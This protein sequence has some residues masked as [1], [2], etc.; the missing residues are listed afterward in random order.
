MAAR[1]RL[2]GCEALR[3]ETERLTAESG[4]GADI[5]AEWLE[6][7]LHQNPESLGR[8]LRTRLSALSGAGYETVLLLFGLCGRATDGLE[9]PPGAKL[10]IPRVHDC[11]SIFLGSARRYLE[12]VDAE[13]GSYWL[14]RT[15]LRRPDRPVP[16]LGGFGS[17]WRDLFPDAGEVP[18][19][20]EEARP[21]LIER[22]GEDNA[23]YLIETLVESWRRNYRRAVH[24]D[25]SD[26]PTRDEDLILA[27]N[28][29][30]RNG[31]SF[32]TMPVDLRLIRMLVS[33]D[34][35]EDEFAIAGPGRRL[36]ATNG[37][38]AIRAGGEPGR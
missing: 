1:I 10:V 6:M 4:A 20:M 24:L 22:Y 36:E 11:V 21:R 35:P 25:W 5:D 9:P 14:S 8:E 34:W 18:A 15:F 7:G 33:G 28:E 19:G 12:E 3:E 13:P 32:Q 27:R 2:I 23:L 29:A 38:D 30:E 17:S 37:R 31:W 26:S 16:G